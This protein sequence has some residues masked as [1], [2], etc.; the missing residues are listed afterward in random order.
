MTNILLLLVAALPALAAQPL[1][2]AQHDPHKL[3]PQELRALLPTVCTGAAKTK[4]GFSCT[5]LPHYPPGGAAFNENTGKAN[6]EISLAAVAYGSFTA[7][8][9]D[10]AYVTYSGLEPH[11]NNFGGGIL[12]ERTRDGWKTIRWIPGGQMDN[13][14]AL[15]G[16]GPQKMLCL[17]SYEG[18]GE[19]DSSI[20]I[21]DPSG[22]SRDATIKR[23]NLL[24]AQDGREASNPDYYCR[25]SLSSHR[26][27]LLSI[28]DLKRSKESGILATSDITYAAA[29]DAREA[30]THNDFSNIDTKSAV[31]R[32]RLV[33][34]GLRAESPAKF[35][36]VD[37]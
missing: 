20:W 23:T 7:K 11:A 32:Y 37:Y 17:S 3:T 31:V 1:P 29:A 14:V 15:P 2:A 10:E 26:D 19:A 16:A 22:L 13:C 12:L 28:D 34:G 27:M 25:A 9:A 36:V 5:A 33:P 8:G 21:L 4:G 24:K 18:M 35:A 30:C 6:G